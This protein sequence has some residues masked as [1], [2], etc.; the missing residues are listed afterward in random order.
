MGVVVRWPDFKKRWVGKGAAV[1]P[2]RKNKNER[3]R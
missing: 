1:S 3:G 2:V